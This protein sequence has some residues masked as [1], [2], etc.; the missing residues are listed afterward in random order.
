MEC[1]SVQ[2]LL[3]AYI[4]KE[5]DCRVTK[6]IKMHLLDCDECYEEYESY[7][8]IK[9]IMSQVPNA[10][11][12]ED[13]CECLMA[14]FSNPNICFKEN[15][16][17]TK[18]K[19]SINNT[20]RPIVAILGLIAI[21]SFTLLFSDDMYNKYVYSNKLIGNGAYASNYKMLGFEYVNQ[22]NSNYRPYEL[23]KS[24]SVREDSEVLVGIPKLPDY[25]NNM[26]VSNSSYHNVFV[27]MTH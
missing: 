7:L 20:G 25:Y 4:D 11:P 22:L 10:E 19:Y 21:L 14:N 26:Y 23:P 1:H 6:E 5:L 13:F 15:I 9:K 3:N 18:Y 12:S 27:G 24:V 2:G 8:M 17:E 16:S